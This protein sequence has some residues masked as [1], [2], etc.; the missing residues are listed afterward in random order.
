VH[1]GELLHGGGDGGALI[2]SRD[3]STAPLDASETWPEP[4]RIVVDLFPQSRFPTLVASGAKL[5]VLCN[6]AD[7]GILGAKHPRSRRRMSSAGPVS[8]AIC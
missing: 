3:W 7:A 2:R 4:L 6:D 8:Q 1:A 5:G